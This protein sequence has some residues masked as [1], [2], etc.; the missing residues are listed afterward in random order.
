MSYPAPDASAERARQWRVRNKVRTHG[1]RSLF[2]FVF[3][4][5]TLLASGQTVYS[6]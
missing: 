6:V 3:S 4:F 5:L 1:G 2:A